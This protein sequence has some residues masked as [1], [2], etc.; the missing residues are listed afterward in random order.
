MWSLLPPEA[1]AI[2]SASQAAYEAEEI[3]QSPATFRN[4][5]RIDLGEGR[6][7]PLGAVL[8]DF[9]RQDFEA[10]D[11]GWQ[12]M[13]FGEGKGR[14][15]RGYL[16]R[17]KGH[18]KT[19]DIA[20]MGSWALYAAARPI[21]GIVA[22]S[23]QEQA[24]YIRDKVRQMLALNPWLR[25]RIV[26]HDWSVK[27]R[28]TGS[29]MEI[30]ATDEAGVH[31]ETPDFVIC[32]ELTHWTKPDFWTAI[33]AG[34]GKL[35]RCMLVV[36]ANAGRGMH[37][38]WQWEAREKCRLSKAWYFHRLE[39]ICKALISDD[40]L[41]EQREHLPP[42]DFARLWLNL[43][44]TATGDALDMTLVEKAIV[45][46]GP[47]TKHEFQG[48][49]GALDLGLTHD[50][51][52]FVVLGLDTRRQ[53]IVLL[54]TRRWSPHDYPDDHRI[55]IMDVEQHVT[56]TCRDLGVMGVAYD[57]YQCAHLAE[58]LTRIHKIDTFPY[59]FT[60]K[61][62]NEMALTLL[63]VF[64]KGQ[65][66]LYNDKSL[67]TDLARLSIVSKPLGFALEAPRDERGHCDLGTALVIGLPWAR[68]TLASYATEAA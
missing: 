17:P 1:V 22:A 14:Y 58:R 44:Q 52:A 57:P 25:A 16:E 42:K 28:L 39:Q 65:V 12:S 8:E 61:N 10:L 18:S 31:G 64:N 9:Q 49:I 38:S 63:D 48:A 36:I 68:D 20:A 2:L 67:I 62:R 30:V 4:N 27:N 32:D 6:I 21:K 23:K 59:E 11:P 37:T 35:E 47:A 26:A 50:H 55:S 3:A 54:H 19:T 43:W 29:E 56:A 13:V 34:A 53:K 60:P 41:A 40:R 7:V 51:S 5:L 66:E 46:P 33:F 15:H 45:L 24:G